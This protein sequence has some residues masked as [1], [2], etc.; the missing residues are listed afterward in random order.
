MVG[1][2]AGSP[3]RRGKR[4]APEA[5]RG[6][7]EFHGNRRRPR[8]VL[9]HGDHAALF[10][11]PAGC[12]LQ[13]QS[14]PGSN[15]ALQS[16]QRSMRADYQRLRVFVKLRPFTRGPVNED[17]NAQVNPAAAPAFQPQRCFARCLIVHT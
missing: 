10:L 16:H 14:L 6:L 13:E 8:H 12:V 1:L 9:I 2:T 17:G 3:I 15:H 7:C 5:W 4:D 11:L